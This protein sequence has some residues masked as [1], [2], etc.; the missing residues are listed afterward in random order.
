MTDP[1]GPQNPTPEALDSTVRDAQARADAQRATVT[2]HAAEAIHTDPALRVTEADE[3]EASD[4]EQDGRLRVQWIRPTDLAAR[5]GARVLE[6]SI[7]LNQRALAPLRQAALEAGRD[8][9]GK[10]RR[11]LAHREQALT[12]DTPTAATAP[13]V[14]RQ[15]VS[16]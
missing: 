13:V 2:A 8:A 10:L 15:E 9:V 4:I 1:N 7:D 14:G 6:G 5:A 3:A 11:A 12:P 16:R